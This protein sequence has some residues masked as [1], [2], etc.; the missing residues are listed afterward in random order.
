MPNPLRYVSMLVGYDEWSL[1]CDSGNHYTSKTNLVQ[2]D[3]GQTHGAGET[4]DE[5]IEDPHRGYA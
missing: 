3:S 5:T 2:G 4:A 1:T